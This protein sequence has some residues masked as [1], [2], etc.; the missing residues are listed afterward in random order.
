MK[1]KG[2]GHLPYTWTLIGAGPHGGTVI[3][4]VDKKKPA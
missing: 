2:S 3:F 1:F 4:E